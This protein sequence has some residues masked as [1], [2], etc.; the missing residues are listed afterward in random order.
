LAFKYDNPVGKV[1]CH[2]KIV[3]DYEGGLLCVKDE[4]VGK[5]FA[6]PVI[7]MRKGG[8]LTA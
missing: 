1:R 5:T 2:D 6:H 7:G 4:T 8:R 3:L